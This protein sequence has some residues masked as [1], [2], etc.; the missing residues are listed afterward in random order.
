[1]FVEKYFYWTAIQI[2]K[3]TIKSFKMYG[4]RILHVLTHQANRLCNVRPSVRKIDQPSYNTLILLLVDLFSN[5]CLKTMIRIHWCINWSIPKH[6]C[7][8]RE[9]Q[10]MLLLGEKYVFRISCHLYP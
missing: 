6:P 8:S 7:I 1:M 5:I 3:Y 2:S 9:I 10:H 4:A